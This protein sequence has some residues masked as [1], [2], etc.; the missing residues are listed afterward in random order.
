MLQLS[1][2]DWSIKDRQFYP[3]NLSVAAQLGRLHWI[4]WKFWCGL[5]G[6]P[7]YRLPRSV[8]CVVG[9]IAS[10][11]STQYQPRMPIADEQ[12]HGQIEMLFQYHTS[13]SCIIARMFNWSIA[14]HPRRIPVDWTTRLRQSYNQQR[15]FY[16]SETHN[17]TQL[18]SQ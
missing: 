2:A 18:A 9:V 1:R 12:R 8:D 16:R 7:S 3:S 13:H 14:W 15:L 5:T 10:L 11:V 6:L 17:S 4:S